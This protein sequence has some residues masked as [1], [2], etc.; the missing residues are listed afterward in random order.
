M[1]HRNNYTVLSID[2]DVVAAKSS[3]SINLSRVEFNSKLQ[4]LEHIYQ[5]VN[6]SK[7]PDKKILH[8]KGTERLNY[9]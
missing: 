3:Y 8:Q 1:F 5:T 2:V 9:I 7:E 4:W 6:K